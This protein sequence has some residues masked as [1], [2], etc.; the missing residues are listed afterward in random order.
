[1]SSLSENIKTVV[2][3]KDRNTGQLVM[4]EGILREIDF[5]LD[6]FPFSYA[7]RQVFGFGIGKYAD[8]L[9][10][11]RTNAELDIDIPSGSKN[12]SVNLELSNGFNK[13]LKVDTDGLNL[14]SKV[15]TKVNAGSGVADVDLT[16]AKK[17]ADLELPVKTNLTEAGTLNGIAGA[18]AADMDV[19]K[20][21]QISGDSATTAVSGVKPGDV[22][23]PKVNKEQILRNIEESRLARKSSNFDQYLAKEKFQKTLMGMEPMDR[24]RY[25]QWH[26]YAEAGIE[27][28]NRV[29]LRNWSYPPEPEFYLKNK[30][31]Y[32]NPDYFNQLTGDTI[33]PGSPE[34]SMGRVD[35]SIHKNGFLNGE[36]V[37]DIIEPGTV[38]DRYGDN[39]SGRYFSPSGASFG[40]RALP[41]FMKNKPKITYIATKPIPN[42]KGLIAPWFDEPGMGIQHFTDMEVGYLMNNGYLKII[43]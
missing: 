5:R 27:P 41:P 22:E 4:E 31:V 39:D 15:K 14:N 18:K 2:N 25:L 10:M 9:K 1:M 7:G 38:L 33:Y 21:K 11:K 8:H 26:K 35:G 28:S 37:E 6:H 40:E 30:N 42:K 24:Q 43:E 16:L 13:G 23:A 32:D 3:I 17:S 34:S 29:K 12:S 36:Y 19:P 20:V